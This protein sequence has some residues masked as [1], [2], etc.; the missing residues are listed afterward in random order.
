MF[1]GIGVHLKVKELYLTE[2]KSVKQI[3]MQ[4]DVSNY[5]VVTCLRKAGVPIR[6]RSQALRLLYKTH[7]PVCSEIKL[8]EE[9]LIGLGIGIYLGEGSKNT[10]H[11][12]K[13]ANTNPDILRLV[14]KFL[15]RRYDVPDEKFK[16]WLHVYNDMDTVL[17]QQYWARELG[18]VDNRI[19]VT[20]VTRRGIGS[21]TN[22]A[23]FGTM[24]IEVNDVGIREALFSDIEKVLKT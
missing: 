22:K 1:Y 9:L 2:G 20:L 24:S 16:Y 4:M 14:I 15:K 17:S 7:A 5:A 11:T 12:I 6:S 3:A 21:Y 23:Y 8:S 10:E 13:V 19:N 18:V